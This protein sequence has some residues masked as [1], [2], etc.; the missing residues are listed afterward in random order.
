MK[1]LIQADFP[2]LEVIGGE[3]PPTFVNKIMSKI[4]S[5]VQLG[6]IALIFLGNKIFQSLGI[7]EP[8]F[9]RYMMEKK[10][11]A[12]FVIFIVG[13]NLSNY[14]YSTGAFEISFMDQVIF[15]KLQSGRMP[16]VHEILKNIE[17]LRGH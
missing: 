12:F 10:M 15:S 4:V 11:I 5:G 16:F 17:V 9:Y 3:Y 13:N 1:E 2:E 14:F 6:L 8:H 7:P